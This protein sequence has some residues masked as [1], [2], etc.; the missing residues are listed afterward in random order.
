[1]VA[2][3]AGPANS[4]QARFRVKKKNPFNKWVESGLLGQIRKSGP[5]MEKPDPNP[6]RCHSYLLYLLGNSGLWIRIRIQYLSIWTLISPRPNTHEFWTS[7]P[8]IASQNFDFSLSQKEKKQGFDFHNTRSHDSSIHT[9]GV[10][11]SCA[12]N[13]LLTFRCSQSA[14]KCSRRR[15]VSH[16]QQ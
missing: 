15:A 4:Q 6:T 2:W 16:I 12:S 7:D 11:N 14:I 1:M 13:L 9:H 5:G 3:L 10:D 8:I